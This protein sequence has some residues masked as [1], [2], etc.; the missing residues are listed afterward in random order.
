VLR[1]VNLFAPGT[2]VQFRGDFLLAGLTIVGHSCMATVCG[3]SLEQESWQHPAMRRVIT[4]PRSEVDVLLWFDDNGFFL[5]DAR[6]ASGLSCRCT[7]YIG[8]HG[9]IVPTKGSSRT[10]KTC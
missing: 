6:T 1:T 8:Y 4:N 7:L 2:D 10:S 9:Y 3:N 5:P